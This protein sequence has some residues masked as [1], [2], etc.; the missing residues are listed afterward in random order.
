VSEKQQYEAFR[1]WVGRLQAIVSEQVGIAEFQEAFGQQ[2]SLDEADEKAEAFL[3]EINKQLRLLEMDL[4]FLRAAR[5]E[6]T[7]RQRW[8]MMGDRLRLLGVYGDGLLGQE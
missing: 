2:P 6:A 1:Q 7:S 3:V 5:Q 8:Q 4:M